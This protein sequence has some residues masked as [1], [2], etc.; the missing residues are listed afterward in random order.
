MK[1]KDF[2]ITI[3]QGILATSILGYDCKSSEEV[4]YGHNEKKYTWQ[5]DWA[6]SIDRPTVNDCHEMVFTNQK[7]IALL[8]NDI[9][10][11][12]I[13]FNKDG[14]VTKTWGTAFP[15]AHGLT[16]H[17]ESEQTLY[18]T[19]TNRHQFYHTTLDGQIIKTWDFPKESEKYT[20]AEEFV[21]TETAITSDGEIY[22]ADG[23]GAQYIIHYD[24]D[25]NLKNIF[26]GRGEEDHHLDN[27]HGICIDHRGDQ[28]LLVITD[29]NRCAFK[30]Y[31][32]DGNYLN[33]IEIPGANMCRPVI[34][35]DYL[36]AAVLTTDFTSNQNTGFVIV[37][38]KENNVVSTIAGSTPD[39]NKSLYQTIQLFQHPHDVCLD[40]DGSLYVC[41]W[42]SN[43]VYPYKF[44][45]H[46]G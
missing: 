31:D 23:Y 39:A 42:N 36:Y 2:I 6:N 4:L 25:G 27:A 34:Q 45:L 22:V 19:D 32:L 18:I 13:F 9:K 30:Y 20:K 11:N 28:P 17:G 44:E 37:L 43:Q 40:D 33:K 21:P 29:R 16:I 8:T 26:G 38:D 5:K 15:G 7:E 3:S 24:A 12:L 10:N 1:R 35:G 41:Q 14:K 46:A